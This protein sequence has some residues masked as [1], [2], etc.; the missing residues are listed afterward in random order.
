MFN[1]VVPPEKSS[2]G[3]KIFS[4]RGGRHFWKEK[5]GRA[6]TRPGFSWKHLRREVRVPLLRRVLAAAANGGRDARD[7]RAEQNHRRGLGDCG[8]LRARDLARQRDGLARVNRDVVDAEGER[9]VAA[10]RLTR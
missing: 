7:A 9:A 2:R 8:L 6:L 3:D 10:G 5:P 4:R 1:G